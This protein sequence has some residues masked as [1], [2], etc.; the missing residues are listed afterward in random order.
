MC[1]VL[2]LCASRL[3][4]GALAAVPDDVASLVPH[5]WQGSWSWLLL[6]VAAAVA[7]EL[8]IFILCF[9]SRCNVIRSPGKSG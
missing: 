4:K 6:A 1:S 7:A 9:T 5:Y 8:A 3:G 2:I